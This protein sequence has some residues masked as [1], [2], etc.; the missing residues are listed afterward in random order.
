LQIARACFGRREVVVEENSYDV[1]ARIADVFNRRGYIFE[2]QVFMAEEAPEFLSAYEKTFAAARLP[3]GLPLKYKECI[4]SA[5]LSSRCEDA[6][7]KNHMHKALAAGA[8][9]HELLD[10]ILT[11]WTP[12]GSI[13]LC[14][15]VKALIEVLV[16]RGEHTLREVPFRVTDRDSDSER[17]FASDQP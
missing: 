15:G 4:Y 17:T 11:A 10:A 9:R 5:V 2:W 3:D 8:T 16:E 1:T 12:T 14:H 13:T 6:L 7:A